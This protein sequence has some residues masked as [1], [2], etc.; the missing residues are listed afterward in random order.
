LCR[1]ELFAS[2]TCYHDPAGG[3][4]ATPSFPGARID[5]LGGEWTFSAVDNLPIDRR[6]VMS[7]GFIRDRGAS[8]AFV[9]CAASY[10]SRCG[11]DGS[12]S[13]GLYTY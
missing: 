4:A 1:P 10:D 5:Y 2:A 7:L 13:G 8:C 12:F 6:Q 9:R 3:G 11:R